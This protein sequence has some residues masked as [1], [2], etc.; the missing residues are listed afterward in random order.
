MNCVSALEVA[1]WTVTIG[2][3]VGEHG[4]V[5]VHHVTDHVVQYGEDQSLYFLLGL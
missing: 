4:V 5:A 2:S 1:H 3:L